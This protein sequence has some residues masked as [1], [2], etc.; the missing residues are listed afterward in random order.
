MSQDLSAKSPPPDPET[1]DVVILG[2]GYAGNCQA[3]HLLLRM[4]ELRLAIVEPRTDDEIAEERK[5]GESTVEIAALHLYKELGLYEYLIENHPPKYG[6]NFHWPRDPG[7]TNTL[8]DYF[9]IW[10]NRNPTVAAF[11]IHRGRLE[12]DLLRMNRE[13]G[14]CHLR[15]RATEIDLKPR[16]QPHRILVELT[17]GETREIQAR[18]LVDAAGRRFLIGKQTDNVVR[19][20]ENHHGLDNGSAWVRVR[21]V[22]KTVFH[23]GFDPE[24]ASASHYYG[25]NHWLGHGHWLWMIPI[26]TETGE[27]SVGIMHHHKTIPAIEINQPDKLYAF[28]RSNHRILYDLLKTGE[29]VDFHYLGKPAHSCRRFF[30]TDN[31]SVIGDAAFIFDAFYS[32]GTSGIAFQI[33]C[34]TELIR[35]Q[36]QGD[37]EL[38]ARREDY[39][40]FNLWFMKTVVNTYR[41]HEKQLGNASV[42]SWRIYYEYIL[43]Y[44]TQVPMYAGKWHLHPGFIRLLCR[45]NN[46]S[47]SAAIYG[48]LNQLIDRN[49]N[50]G[51][52]DCH[53]ADQLLGNFTTWRPTDDYLENSKF[54]PQHLNIYRATARTFRRVCIWYAKFRWKGFGL[55]GLLSPRFQ[56]RW[57]GLFLQSWAMTVLACLHALRHRGRKKNAKVAAMRDAFTDYRHQAQLVPWQ[58]AAPAA[59]E[60]Q[61]TS[62]QHPAA[63]SARP[64]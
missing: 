48:E 55:W 13:M 59:S 24:S 21:G 46:L 54:A 4:P 6:L 7:Q 53:R 61:S 29:M 40:D 41:D 20:P 39:N 33:E 62:V 14:A 57:W 45:F 34:A 58:T 11:Q 9:S 1:F 36:L 32:L 5:I 50:L 63:I 43:W 12:R 27:V 2:G 3:R 38:E 49:A 19:G 56:I 30:S 10:T 35:M 60:P 16:E 47:F 18:H 15:G 42:M 22:D 44:G 8:E 52:M 31:W 28:L 23:S 25:T 26:D 64:E 37:A 51:F 17:N